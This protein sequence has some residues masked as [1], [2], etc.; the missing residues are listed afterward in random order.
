MVLR[1]QRLDPGHAEGV[2]IQEKSGALPRPVS[3]EHMRLEVRRTRHLPARRIDRQ[4][5]KLAFPFGHA[6]Q[7]PINCLV[8]TA[9][10]GTKLTVRHQLA[11]SRQLLDFQGSIAQA[12]LDR[13][14]PRIRP[15]EPVDVRQKRP[16]VADAL[17]EPRRRRRLE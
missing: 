10:Q 13:D 15:G 12:L 2:G 3:C 6:N 8:D 5:L 9:V 17:V 1:V 16:C 4:Q 11:G 7:A 14:V